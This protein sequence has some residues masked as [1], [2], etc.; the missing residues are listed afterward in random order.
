M[1]WQEISN[2]TFGDFEAKN[3]DQLIHISRS[4]KFKNLKSCRKINASYKD[5]VFKD[6]LSADF[7][8]TDSQPIK[9]CLRRYHVL[10]NIL[11]VEFITT[12]FG[13]IGTTYNIIVF[14]QFVIVVISG[15]SIVNF[16]RHTFNTC[17][18]CIQQAH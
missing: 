18:P 6:K 9:F 15:P 8:S 3:I 4:I 11:Y 5:K 14:I 2:T 12:V 16:R 1:F 13:F 7:T 17:A 10:F